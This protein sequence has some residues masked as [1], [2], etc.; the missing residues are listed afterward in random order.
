M[1][2]SSR[3]VTSSVERSIAMPWPASRLSVQR[4][5]RELA[6]RGHAPAA[7][8]LPMPPARS[9]PFQRGRLR[10]HDQQA[11]RPAARTPVFAWPNARRDVDISRAGADVRCEVPPRPGALAVDVDHR[12]VAW[13]SRQQPSRCVADCLTRRRRAIS[14]DCAAASSALALGDP[15]FDISISGFDDRATCSDRR[16]R[17]L[18]Q[19]FS[20][21]GARLSFST[22]SARSLLRRVRWSP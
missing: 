4:R 20:R 19:R 15:A 6:D 9:R 12:I 17:A 22:P 13:R 16:P 10:D 2:D 14:S 8:R 18:A 11:Q 7:F 3:L 21:P 1:W 5:S